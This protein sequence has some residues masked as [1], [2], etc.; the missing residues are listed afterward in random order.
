MPR[1]HLIFTGCSIFREPEFPSC[2]RHSPGSNDSTE[3]LSH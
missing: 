3:V 2:A 1:N